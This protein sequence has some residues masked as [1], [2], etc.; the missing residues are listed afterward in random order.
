MTATLAWRPTNPRK[1]VRA[2]RRHGDRVCVCAVPLT[3]ALPLPAVVLCEE[4]INSL[5]EHEHTFKMIFP[6]YCRLEQFSNR[7][8]LGS[9]MWRKLMYDSKL[10]PR[11]SNAQ[12][13]LAFQAGLRFN[14]VRVRRRP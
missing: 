4:V 12:L 8:Y 7:E 6:F 10:A 2:M 13:D 5:R 9:S 14:P 3:R 11:R 1:L